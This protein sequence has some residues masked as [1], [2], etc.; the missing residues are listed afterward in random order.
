MKGD[1]MSTLVGAESAGAPVA[2]F[3]RAR[4][5]ALD[6]LDAV[7]R[8]H[9]EAVA[10]ARRVAR[11]VVAGRLPTAALQGAQQQCRDAERAF[12][13]PDVTVRQSPRRAAL[14]VALAALAEGFSCEPS[15]WLRDLVSH[16]LAAGAS[17]ARLVALIRN[18]YVVPA[19]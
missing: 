18:H 12:S 4:S 7:P 10:E 5:F 14:H 1:A 2:D 16:A 9:A 6:V 8:V 19:A 11:A 13:R 17:N 3:T 15:V